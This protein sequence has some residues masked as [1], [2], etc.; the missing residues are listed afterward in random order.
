MFARIYRPARTATQSGTAKTR[1]WALEFA[2]ESRPTLDPLMGWTGSS[3]MRSQVRLLFSDRESAERY[4][5]DNGIPYRVEEP[6]AR[7]HI[8]R[9]RG[10]GSNFS[11]DRREGWTH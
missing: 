5:R 11:H 1:K 10:Y 9:E 2:P 6:R 8:I 3:D 4:A 7:Q